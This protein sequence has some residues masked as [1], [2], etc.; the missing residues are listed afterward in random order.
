MV[1]SAKVITALVALLVAGQG[2][3]YPRVGKRTARKIVTAVMRYY[4][5][6]PVLLLSVFAK[7]SGFRTTACYRG[8]HGLGQVQLGDKS[9]TPEARLRARRLGLY[10]VWWAVRSASRLAKQWKRFC[11][12]AH[13]GKHDWLLHYNQGFGFCRKRRCRRKDYRPITRGHIGG[14]GKRVRRICQKM[15]SRLPKNLRGE[16]GT[17]KN[18]AQRQE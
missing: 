14:Y 5:E 18:S 12:A 10:N 3:D 15:L 2:R 16:V 8:A 7:E 1:L 11:L 9:C 17:C 6:N 4:K 13:G